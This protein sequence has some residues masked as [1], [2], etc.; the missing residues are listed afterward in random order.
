[1]RVNGQQIP[2]GNASGNVGTAAAMANL[3][4]DIP[5]RPFGLPLQPYVG[6]GLGY[7][8]TDFGN[9]HGNGLATF[10]LPGNK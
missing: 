6:A 4:Y 7:G 1:M 3:V 10:A 5:M 8:W 9:A 2:L